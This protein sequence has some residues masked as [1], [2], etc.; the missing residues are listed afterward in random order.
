MDKK[1]L[2]NYGIDY[3]NE[4]LY[5]MALN[6]F[7]IARPYIRVITK[8]FFMNWFLSKTRIGV[9]REGRFG[10]RDEQLQKELFLAETHVSHL[11]DF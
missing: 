10:G 7:A 3:V 5:P 6:C 1:R 2:R 4:P 11:T 8:N 9:I